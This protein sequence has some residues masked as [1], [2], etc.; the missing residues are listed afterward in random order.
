MA[1]LLIPTRSHEFVASTLQRHDQQH[2]RLPLNFQGCHNIGTVI[3]RTE[4]RRGDCGRTTAF[5][6]HLDPEDEHLGRP[7]VAF[8]DAAARA[9]NHNAVVGEARLRGGS[10]NPAQWTCPVCDKSFGTVREYEQHKTVPR[11]WS[12]AFCR[13][14]F[15]A[16]EFYTH[17]IVCRRRHNPELRGMIFNHVSP[18]YCHGPACTFVHL[19]YADLNHHRS[20]QRHWFCAS[21]SRR[22]DTTIACFTHLE[23]C[24]SFAGTSEDR[25]RA[26][27]YG[28]APVSV[29]NLTVCG[30]RLRGGSDTVD[31]WTCNPAGCPKSYSNRHQLVKHKLE[32]SH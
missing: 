32:S 6:H 15:G 16:V 1:S 8:G 4:P 24:V 21:C 10:D 12:C 29:L 17:S 13:G 30:A 9:S 11:Q 26:D 14:V 31:R 25:G 22:F 18:N 23:I 28:R 20:R 7:F 19:D 27:I 3:S 2:G 5:D